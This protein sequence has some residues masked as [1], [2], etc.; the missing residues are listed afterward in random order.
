MKKYLTFY[1][2]IAER[3]FYLEQRV[4]NVNTGKIGIVREIH[5]FR[6]MNS[7]LVQYKSGKKLYKGNDI[8]IVEGI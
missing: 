8:L 3:Y 2:D 6:I 4:R 7:I 5:P 1:S